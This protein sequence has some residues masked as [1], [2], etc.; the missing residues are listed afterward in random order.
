MDENAYRQVLSTAIARPCPFEKSILTRCV[1]CSLAEKHSVAEREVV[2]CS[3]E[4]SLERC[5]EL[6]DAL[7]HSFAFALHRRDTADPLT[8]AQEMRVQCGGLKGLQFALDRGSEVI[9]VAA[10]VSRAR[11]EYGGWA[12][13][14]YEQIV[15]WAAGNYR[16]R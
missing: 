3:D 14:P 4:A 7:R 8:H 15:Q 12:G 9:D 11:Q 16:P 13:F 5:V 10:L 6:H 1:T 2:A